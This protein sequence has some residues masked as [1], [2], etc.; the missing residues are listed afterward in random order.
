MEYIIQNGIYHNYVE[1]TQ[2]LLFI[3]TRG[4]YIQNGIYHNYVEG[5]QGHSQMQLE[6]TYSH[7]KHTILRARS[8]QKHSSSP[9]IKNIP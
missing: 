3:N 1:G 6:Y 9:D 4:V 8:Q 2:D 7:M 5:T